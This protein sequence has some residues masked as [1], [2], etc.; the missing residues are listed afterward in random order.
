MNALF[1]QLPLAVQLRDDATFDN[2]Y[3]AD[4]AL[5]VNQVQYQLANVEPY[6]FICGAQGSGRS[7]LLQASCHAADQQGLA[8]VYLPL[9]ELQHYSPNELFEGLAALSLVCLDN[10]EAVMGDSA[11]EK[12]IFHLFNDLRE[13]EHSLLVAADRGVKQ[14]PISMPDLA[15]R[16][17]WGSFY[18]LK[19]LDDEQRIAVLKFRA[20]R[21]GL[22]LSD[23][24][25]QFVS[26]R[27]HRTIDALMQT[28]DNL[29]KA[30]LKEQR[31]LTIPFVKDALGW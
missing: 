27:G 29:D 26:R 5:A 11:W 7:H 10:I 22:E 28:L 13:A 31:K 24:V 14:L 25:A 17:G 8:S 18:Q 1:E 21:R 12:A 30:S 4:N 23:E 6:I 16:L 9:D 2:F 3:P 15:S 20:E 19:N